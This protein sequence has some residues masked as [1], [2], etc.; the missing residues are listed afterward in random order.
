[1]LKSFLNVRNAYG[2]FLYFTGI[3]SGLVLFV[4]MW[5]IDINALSRK[6]FNAPLPGGVEVTQSLLAVAIMLPFGYVLVKR[7]HVNTVFLT[8]RFSPSFNRWLHFFWM[9]IGFLL[10]ASVAYGTYKFALRSY[11]M[12]EQVWGATIRFPL[13]PAK[14]AVSLGAALLSIQF[15][16]DALFALF[17]SDDGDLSNALPSLES[18]KNHV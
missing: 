5:I 1:M 17:N 6:I 14:L 4:M 2:K 15:L 8:S 3:A 7:E 12:N 10:F 18:V 11:M 9:L 13:Y 16:L